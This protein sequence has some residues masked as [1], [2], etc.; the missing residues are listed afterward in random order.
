MKY[1]ILF[2]LS[3]Y[4]LAID[5]QKPKVY[6]GNENISGWIMSEKLDGIRGVWNGEDL[7]T[8]KGKK[9]LYTKMV[10]KRLPSF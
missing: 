8:R 10:Y 9:N 6:T 1:I 2:I 4:A 3:I 7:L 5:I